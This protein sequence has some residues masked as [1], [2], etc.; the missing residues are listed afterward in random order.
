MNNINILISVKALL[1]IIIAYIET[2]VVN[3]FEEYCETLSN[4]VIKTQTI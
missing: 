1:R 3:S 2:S 4:E